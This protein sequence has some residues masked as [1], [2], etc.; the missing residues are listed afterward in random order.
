MSGLYIHI[1]FCH[2]KCAY[3][4]FF[5]T[6]NVRSQDLVISA[7]I[8]EFE[9]R[10]DELGNID[11]LYIGGGTPS[12]LEINQLTALVNL[13]DTSKVSEI[14][15]EVN[16]E[17]ITYDYAKAIFDLGINRVSMGVQSFNDEELKLINRRHSAQDA[18]NAIDTLNRA[19][20]GNISCDLIYG[21]PQQTMDSWKYSLS[22]LFSNEIKHFS[23]YILSYEP[24]TLLYT[25]LTTG[26]IVEAP[27][28]LIEEMY[29][30][31]ISEASKN[32]FE[33]YEISNFS[34]PG[35]KSIHNSN[36]WLD[37]PYLGLGPAA[38]SYTH[39][40]RRINPSNIKA[41]L[42]G[43]FEIEDENDIDRINDKI[44]V[45]LRQSIGLNLNELDDTIQKQLLKQAQPFLS[46]GEL[47]LNNNYLSIRESAWLI[48]DM[49]I[50]QILQS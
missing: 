35:Y 46:H 32:G 37:K 20:I 28:E 17:D 47:S 11:T 34:I 31:L 23:A 50:R 22:T 3:C 2:S 9:S 33:H 1:P 30:Y 42:E 36:Y 39:N 27:D 19:G 26:K 5:S 24:G 6:P 13:I 41:Y 16:P 25:K 38:H 4:D 45:G 44:F 43:K 49:I 40:A 8:K 18:L 21:L 12:I 48:S 14:T 29:Q 10:K 7:I 15:I